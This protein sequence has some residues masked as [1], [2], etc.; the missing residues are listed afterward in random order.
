MKRFKKILKWTL[1]VILV[2]VAGISTITA[3][4]QNTTYKASYPAI[5]ASK[6]SAVIARGKHLVF[7]IAHCADCHSVANTD[8]LLKLGLDVP[9]SGGRLF[10]LPVGDIYSKNITPDKRN[11]IGRYTDGEVA[12]VLRYGVHANGTA[13]FDFMPFHNMSDEDLTAVI[14]YLR[15]QKPVSK[16]APEHKLNVMGNL[17]KAFMVKPVG[18]E[19]EVARSVTPD[20][21]ATYGKYLV[22]SLANCSGCHTQRDLTGGFTGAPFAGG[23]V[24]VRVKALPGFRFKARGSDLRCDLRINSRR[25]TQGGTEM[26][27]GITGA[28]LRVQIPPGVGRGAVLRLPN[29]GLPKPRGGR[30]DLLV[31]ITYRLDIRILRTP[32]R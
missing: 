30:G 5:K 15:I 6:D 28:M 7:D 23:F 1:L 12:R 17:V 8:S 18:P 13:V 9:L 24:Q 26:I 4:R 16:P 3:T 19:G 14:S 10:A 32:G 20:T 27:Q 31:R 2:L 22:F 29:E 25:A 21:T 11:G